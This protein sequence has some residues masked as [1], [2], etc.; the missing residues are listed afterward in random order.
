MSMAHDARSNPRA[1][2]LG[3]LSAVVL[4]AL[5]AGLA[6]AVTSRVGATHDDSGDLHACV[7]RY[8]GALRY[9]TD[10]AR[11]SSAEFP[12]TLAAGG[13]DAAPVFNVRTE[14]YDGEFVSGGTVTATDTIACQPGEVAIS[15]GARLFIDGVLSNGGSA[16]NIPSSTPV[17]NP[18][19]E[20]SVGWSLAL[21]P[22]FERE[23]RV[24]YWVLCMS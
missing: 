5:G 2:V 21:P 18:P 23:V 10:P 6:L 24:E 19:S 22:D 4:M 11:C 7:H 1:Y 3:V 20:W 15:G 14:E 16:F 8:T 9:V 13:P 17:G 12:I